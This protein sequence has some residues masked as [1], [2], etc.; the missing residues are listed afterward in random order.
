[1]SSPEQPQETGPTP[2]GITSP[3][4]E[5]TGIG[6][7]PIAEAQPQAPGT[8]PEPSSLWLL[9]MGVAAAWRARRR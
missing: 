3:A 8:I 6:P 7:R 5:L 1:M 9:A 2:A 4:N